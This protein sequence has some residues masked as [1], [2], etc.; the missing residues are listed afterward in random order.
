MR[1]EASSGEGAGELA[2]RD[3]AESESRVA[4]RNEE[5]RDGARFEL[6]RSNCACLSGRAE[7][8]PALQGEERGFAPI[9]V[10]F[11]NFSDFICGSPGEF[12]LDRYSLDVRDSF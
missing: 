1:V 11:E 8:A 6:L 12:I 2:E 10:A 5:R 3:T 4:N 7:Q 9:A